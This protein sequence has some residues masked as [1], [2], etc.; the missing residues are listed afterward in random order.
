MRQRVALFVAL[1]VMLAAG[2]GHPVRGQGGTKDAPLPPC[3]AE[4]A[5]K[6]I[7]A[8]SRCF[9]LRIYTVKPGAGTIDTL[10]GRFREQSLKYFK[11]HN[12][13]IVG[14]WQPVDRPNNLIYLLAFRDTA[15]RDA[16]WAA[17][18]A[19]AEFQKMIKSIPVALSIERIF[20][21]STD[22]GPMK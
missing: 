14:F 5:G 8:D 13:T 10:H 17:F 12:V 21:R 16:K 18:G 9:E 7:A 22:Y 4:V 1:A 20:M 15:E 6:N 11:K 19:D 2:P 3:G